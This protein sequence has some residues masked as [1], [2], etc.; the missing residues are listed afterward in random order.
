MGRCGVTAALGLHCERR[1]DLI[2]LLCDT[3]E[4]GALTELFQ[5]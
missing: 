3:D 2:N 4:R 5:L 1:V